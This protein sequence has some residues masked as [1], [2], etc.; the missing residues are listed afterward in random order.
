MEAQP[1]ASVRVS[2]SVCLSLMSDKD[3][4]IPLQSPDAL[5][6]KPLVAIHSFNANH[7]DILPRNGSV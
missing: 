6:H 3:G 4:A 2:V 5:S 1:R 7:G